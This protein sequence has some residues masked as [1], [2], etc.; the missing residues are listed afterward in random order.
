MTRSARGP[1][2]ALCVVTLRYDA[3]LEAIDAA[4]PRHV[5]WLEERIAARELLVGGRQVPRTGGVL[6]M[7]GERAE[8]ARLV[9]RDPFVSE[10]LAAAE[11]TQFRASFAAPEFGELIR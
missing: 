11:I 8:V 5:A 10:G 6:L 3:P 4:M 2:S 9:Q 1:G 7:R